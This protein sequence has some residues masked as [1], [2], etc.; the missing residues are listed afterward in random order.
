MVINEILSF[1][2]G[3]AFG[4][5]FNVLIYRL[6][7]NMSLIAPPSHCPVCSNKLKWYHNIPLLSYIF[8][9]GKCAYC[10]SKI[11]ISYFLVELFTSLGFLLI[12]LKDGFTLNY[13]I[14]LTIFS[15]LLVQSFIDYKYMEVPSFLNDILLVAGIFY[16]VYD[17]ELSYIIFSLIVSGAFLLLYF[18]YKGK[19]GFGDVKIFIALSA[20]F[21]YDL[22]YIILISSL[23]GLFV[24]FILSVN[25]K[26]KMSSLKLPF[27]PYIF[28]GVIIYWILLS[29]LRIS[30]LTSLNI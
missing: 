14:D 3:A 25:R 29:I 22:I 28:L 11:P 24:A 20:F 16:L 9:G 21:N 30:T 4:S 6:P 12:F 19:F 8:L 2:F 23:A 17:Y 10:G 18:I 26:V 1:V 15:I 5:F 13:I 27:I 7:N